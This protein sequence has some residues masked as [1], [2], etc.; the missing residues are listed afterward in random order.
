M[1]VVKTHFSEIGKNSEE[2]S[3]KNLF[4]EMLKA[5][6]KTVSMVKSVFLFRKVDKLV[7]MGCCRWQS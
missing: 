7:K 1:W 3:V 6:L 4:W 5:L 2:L